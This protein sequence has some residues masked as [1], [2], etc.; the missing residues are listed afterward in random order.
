LP[1]S[2]L[3]AE[4]WHH[5]SRRFALTGHLAQFAGI[6]KKLD[7]AWKKMRCTNVPEINRHIRRE[8]RKGWEV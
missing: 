2:I 1:I 8:Y 3:P 7:R 5:S 6:G 4:K